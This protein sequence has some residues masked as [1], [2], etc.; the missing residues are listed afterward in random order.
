VESARG[1]VEG[2]REREREKARE[3]RRGWNVR[4]GP[5]RETVCDPVNGNGRIAKCKGN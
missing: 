2:G 3:R 5:G 4:K 1:E